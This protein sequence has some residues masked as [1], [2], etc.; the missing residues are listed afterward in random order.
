M[1]WTWLL[2][3]CEVAG[4]GA[5]PPVIEACVE[6]AA[7]D[8]DG[9]GFLGPAAGCGASAAAPDCDDGDPDVHPGGME[10]C[11]GR[12]DDCDGWVDDDDPDHA[13]QV[14]RDADGDG[15]GDLA[16]ARWGCPTGTWV[17][18]AGDC[19]DRDASAH[20]GADEGCD[21]RDTDCDGLLGAG[22]VDGDGDGDPAC[23]D[24]ADDDAARST[25]AGERC[26]GLDNDCDGLVD[27]DDDS[28]NPYTC[29]D[30]CPA[31]LLADVEAQ[32]TLKETRRNPCVLDPATEYLCEED[33][34]L[35]LPNQGKR[36]HRALVR[37]DAPWRDQLFLFLPPGPGLYNDR[38]RAWATYAGYRT[39]SLGY[40]NEEKM[41]DICAPLGDGCYS[42]WRYEVTYGVDLSPFIQ[43]SPAD[44]IMGRL[45]TVLAAL[46]RDDPATWGGFL[47]AE[48]RPAWEKIVVSG[49]SIG[50]GHAAFVAKHHPVHGVMLIS[51]PKDRVNDPEPVPSSWLLGPQVIDGCRFTGIYHADEHFVKPPDDVLS[52]A[53]AGLGI[54][55]P[56]FHLESDATGF[57]QSQAYTSTY[58]AGS[59]C[60]GHK[61]V[62]HDDCMPITYFDA[63]RDL[64]CAAAEQ[65]FC[66][67]GG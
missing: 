44:S 28:V 7:V 8:A 29:G 34:A 12:D 3:A 51:G 36:M 24:C 57:G 31:E 41:E 43:I 50:S 30:Y 17:A 52:T 19:D 49:W 65:R 26:D 53:W 67:D 42:D 10:Q 48:G 20:P 66:D 27:Q 1:M 13:L 18:T 9:D 11:N 54:A 25:L 62:G 45:E 64:M 16:Q 23:A 40:A 46:E 63:Y 6:T 60:R 21:G 4:P 22:E 59:A 58:D 39:L 5:N 2:W 55:L 56:A 35:N 15:F 32:A 38:L 33:E 47:D 14:F 37:T 61:T